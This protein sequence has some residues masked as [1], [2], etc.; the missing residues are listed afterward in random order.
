VKTL[1]E[2]APH[3]SRAAR[4]IVSNTGCTSVCDRLMTRRISLV[5]VCC[6]S[7]SVRSR[8]RPCSSSNS[9]TFSIAMTAWSANV[10]SSP[11]WASENGLTSDRQTPMEP[12]ARPSRRSGTASTVRAPTRAPGASRYRGSLTR[13]GVWTTRHSSAARPETVS[14]PI[15]R[16]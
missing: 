15:R 11:I 6:S 8:L 3:S 16:G 2:V 1:P 14:G 7:A 4:A 5:A 12:I 13:S 9:R 10:E